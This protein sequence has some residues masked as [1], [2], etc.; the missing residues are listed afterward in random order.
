MTL[1][2][3]DPEKHFRTTVPMDAV[4]SEGTA[5]PSSGMVTYSRKAPTHGQAQPL[6]TEEH[7][8]DSRSGPFFYYCHIPTRSPSVLLEK[9]SFSPNI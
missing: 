9:F 6:I 2:Q 3:Q 7:L 1:L 5:L 4:T 8:N